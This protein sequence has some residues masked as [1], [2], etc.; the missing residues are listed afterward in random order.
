[1][2]S[3]KTFRKY[4]LINS[5]KIRMRWE[6]KISKRF[7]HKTI[8]GNKYSSLLSLLGISVGCFAMVI[9][10]SV[11]NGFESL[12]HEKLKGFDGDIRMF[13][14]IKDL[15]FFENI[16]AIE[17]IMPFME[18]R[19][20][21][22]TSKN[23]KIVSLKAVDERLFK[24][25]YDLNFRGSELKHNQIFIGEDLSHRLEKDIGGKITIYSPLDQSIGLGIPYKK[26]FIIAGIFKTK[27]L[28]YDDRFIFMTLDDGKN[29]F[30]RKDAID[31]FDLRVNTESSIK[32]VKEDLKA[33]SDNKIE[34]FTWKD[35]NRSL[36][37]AMKI[38]RIATMIILSLIFL[39][40]TFHLASSLTLISYQKIKELGILRVMGASGN[41]IIN[42]IVNIGIRKAGKGMIYGTGIGLLVVIMQNKISFIKI[43]TDIYFVQSLPMEISFSEISSIVIVSFSFIFLASF[44]IGRKISKINT[45][46]A[47]KW[48]K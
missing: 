43:P 39:V 1:M 34:I 35:L 33:L 16:N 27:V 22:E 44:I 46:E 17:S 24:S 21:A 11:M 14:S 28:D 4:Q 6:R 42:I 9:S 5:S 41:S 37:D 3:C 10:L 19:G 25:F 2:G 48:K 40:S 32:A 12:V 8:N 31:G 13:S 26:E 15:T 29:L 47:L 36:V 20:V 18:R 30:R 23:Q 7:Y 45:M 38:E